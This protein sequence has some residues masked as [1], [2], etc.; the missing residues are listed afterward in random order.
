MDIQA[1]IQSETNQS[2]PWQWSGSQRQRALIAC[3]RDE[4]FAV[5]LQGSRMSPNWTPPATVNATRLPLRNRTRQ[6][7]RRKARHL[8][9]PLRKLLPGRSKKRHRY[10]N[11]MLHSL[12]LQLIGA[13]WN[14]RRHSQSL[15]CCR[16]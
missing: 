8:T 3:G 13:H 10:S 5:P 15:V 11:A 4:A 2:S 6:K 12:D 14:K 7:P 9:L 1:I 16:L